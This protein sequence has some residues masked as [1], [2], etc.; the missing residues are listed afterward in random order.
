VRPFSQWSLR[1]KLA[2]ALSAF[3]GVISLSIFVELPARLRSQAVSATVENA[4]T[5]TELA[6]FDL[7]A[8]LF[9]E[10]GPGLEES[11]SAVRRDADLVY[12]VVTDRG[13]RVAAGFNA[14]LA[15][16][17]GYRS[18]PMAP[19]RLG[20]IPP[21]APKPR[22]EGGFAP[23]DRVYQVSS[24]VSYNGRDIGRVTLGLSLD[25]LNAEIAGSRRT[26]AL[27]CLV[28]FLTGI[29][30][31][32]ALSTVFT[33]PLG[34]IVAASQVIAGG[35]LTARAPVRHD[36]EVGR[37]ARAFNGMVD[38]LE[39]AQRELASRNR[40]L[41]ERYR[42]FVERNLAG[43]YVVTADGRPL[44]CNDACARL[45][46]FESA[47][48]FLEEGGAIATVDPG[49]RAA[50]LVR[51][52]HEGAVSNH[53]VALRRRD[54]QVVWALE[55]VRLIDE[56][57]GEEAILEGILLDIT[58]RKRAE[59]EVERRAL[60]D[61][62]TLLPNRNLFGDRLGVALSLARRTQATPAV[63]FL[64]VDDL[65]VV[66]DTLGH[67]TGDL[68]LRMI[69]DRLRACLREGDTVARIGGDEFTI[70]LPAVPGENE[71]VDVARKILEKLSEP[72]FVADDELHVTASV[73][74]AMYPKN[75][76]TPESL[77][78]SADSAMY[79]VK[80][81][82]GNGLE[83]AEQVPSQKA[84]G[85]LSLEEELR[86]GLERGEFVLH[87][88]P[89]V[90]I[91][92]N[93]IVGFEALVRWNHPEQILVEPKGFIS[94]A[95]YSGLIIPIGEWVLHEACR[96]MKDWEDRGLEGLSVAVNVSAR[97]F[98]Q[99][100]FMGMVRRVLRKT[101][102]RPGS[103]ELEITESLA[104]QKSDWSNRILDELKEMGV[105]IALDDFGTGQSSLSYLRRFPIDSVKIDQSFVK[106]LTRNSNVDS[107]VIATLLLAN[108]IALRTVA[109]GVETAGQLEFLREHGCLEMQGYLVSRALPANELEERFIRPLLHGRPSAG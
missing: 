96:Q 12:V 42:L 9:F 83:I 13:G 58:D 65:K 79:R 33:E 56:G 104:V 18:I 95:E 45:F 6:A 36:D 64:D 108:R 27:V 89:Q 39:A 20:A 25:R 34:R 98:Y 55:S 17:S 5:M 88:Q 107:I 19:R 86:R 85:R 92:T 102:L 29:A 97:Q 62:L 30:T 87:Y 100:D 105:G 43:V 74:V 63:L 103:L 106:D 49:D 52:R 22:S 23:D 4:F 47:R 10:D 76:E 94:L 69:A 24:P 61:E 78:R 41:E 101:G 82:G 70:L 31:V 59:L 16:R 37:L 44:D 68:L 109:E 14:D 28:I 75:G 53:E 46:G 72:Y 32:F 51:L 40:G 67:G 8:A 48:E 60:H 1:T 90:N 7:G 73:G 66:N 38:R 11:L 2:A 15:E 80:V 93:A 21:G 77:L 81:A 84:L 35:D 71:A 26:I 54:G 57:P 91:R 3:L 99:R 50:L